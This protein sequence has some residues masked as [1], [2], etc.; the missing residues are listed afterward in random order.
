[1]RIGEKVTYRLAQR[2]GSY[3]IPEYVRPV[4]TL[5][6][7]L[8]IATTPAP[9]NVIEK[10]VADVS[11]LAGMLPDE[12]CYHLPLYRQHQRLLQSGIQLSR[13]TLTTRA[14][15]LLRPIVDAQAQ[16]LLQSRVLAMD[17]VPI[18][19]GRQ[20]YF[21]PIYG[22]DDESVFHDAPSRA[23]HHVQAFLGEFSA[24]LLSDGYEAYAAYARHNAEVTHAAC[25]SH[26]RRHFEAAKDSEPAASTEA[27]ALIGALYRHEEVSRERGLTGKEKLAYR[28]A[29]SEPV[30]QAFRTWCDRQY[31]RP[32]LLPSSPPWPR[33]CTA[34]WRA[35]QA[36]RCSW[37]I[38]RWRSTPTTW[39]VPCAPSP[40]ERRTGCSPG[41]RSVRNASASSKACS[42]PPASRAWTPTP[43]WSMCC[44]ASACSRPSASASLPPVSGRRDS[45]PIP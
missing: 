5:L 26:C 29:H 28:S 39:S 8:S 22:E 44:S 9:A 23:H 42:L 37:P 33:R 40:W 27:L 38:P 20:A 32:D 19:A 25:W 43:T 41:R 35:R 1:V 6:D 4:Y 17:E 11:F 24:T 31:H 13:S 30:V 7:D 45:P 36:C 12:F 2:P 14:I 16:H 15:D 3:V 21:W 10:S 18:K 34:L